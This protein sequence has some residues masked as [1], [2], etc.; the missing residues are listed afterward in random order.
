MNS[1]SLYRT[2][3]GMAVQAS[4]VLR[5]R[6]LSVGSSVQNLVSG[7]SLKFL[8]SADI[9][10]PSADDPLFGLKSAELMLKHSMK[11]TRLSM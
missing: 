7:E 3:N 4:T 5:L 6:R 2:V 8:W 10:F 9:R 1:T 11:R